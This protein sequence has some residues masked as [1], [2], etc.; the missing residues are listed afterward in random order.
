MDTIEIKDTGKG[1]FWK[2]IG[3]RM[4]LIRK[5][6]ELEFVDYWPKQNSI[7]VWVNQMGSGSFKTFK[8]EDF[9]VEELKSVEVWDLLTDEQKKVIENGYIQAKAQEVINTEERRLGR[10][11]KA[12]YEGI[13]R[14]IKCIRCGEMQ[15][16]APAN[17]LKYV[18]KAGQTI[19]EWVEQFKCSDCEPRRRGKQPSEKW[20]NLPREIHCCENGCEFVL[21]QHPSMTDKLAKVKGIS[22]EEYVAIWKCKEHREKK[23]HHF[24]VMK[25][26]RLEKESKESKVE[27]KEPVKTAMKGHRGRQANPI[28]DGLPKGLTCCIE[29]CG[30]FQVQ[31]PSI[32]IKIA[33][34]KGLDLKEYMGNWKCKDHREKKAHPMSK[35][36]RLAREKK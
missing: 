17:V 14:E 12:E 30:F 18:E 1:L 4:I 23:P 27:V 33:G 35:E 5:G 26:S 15:V 20:L 13:P 7:R 8:V 19:G 3:E 22:F 6:I 10:Q 24:T 25:E 28:Y 29:G 36:G 16:I 21:K 2:P 31:H 11:P 32:S 34:S 9:S